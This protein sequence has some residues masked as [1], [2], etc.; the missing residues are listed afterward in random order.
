MFGTLVVTLPSSYLGGAL[1]IRHGRREVTVETKAADPSEL[2]YVAF[3][4]DCEHETLPVRQ[5]SRVCLVYNLVQQRSKGRRRIQKAPEYESQITEAATILDRFLNAADAP[6][7]IVWLLDH[8]YS[9]AGLSFSTLK[10]ADAAKA[11]VLLRAATKAQCAAHL[12]IVHIG[13]SGEAESDFGYSY[14][15][16]RRSYAS[17][18]DDYNDIDNEDMD[19]TAASVD[20]VWRYI[21]EWRDTDDR[22]AAFGRIPLADG[23]LLP[24]GALDA[25]PPDKQ[26][27]TEA[28]GN[29]GA[30]YERSY[31][32]AALVVWLQRSMA[33]VLL[34]AGAVAALP[35]LKKL[36]A[37]GA[38]ERPEA[39]R[40]AERMLA[41]WSDYPNHWNAYA[42]YGA[43]PEPSDRR[44]MIAAL[45][46]LS[47]PALLE[48]FL[49]EAI[50]LSYDGS[51]NSALVSSVRV[52]GEDSAPGV[53]SAL[54]SARMP[55]HPV[56]C[57]ELLLALARKPAYAFSEVAE[58]AVAGIDRIGTSGAESVTRSWQP[59]QRRP[60]TPEFLENLLRALQSFKTGTL[61]DAAAQ[62]IASR[63]EIFS[64]V[65][66]VVPAIERIG[67]RSR[68]VTTPFDQRVKQYENEI[69][70]MR[71]L[72]TLADKSGDGALSGRM[73]AAVKLAPDLNK[74]KALSR[75]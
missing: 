46:S 69:A 30:T 7:K 25:E 50:T 27:V 47:A 48:R 60:L 16:R 26:R 29:E 21:D 40:V 52:L 11:R 64:P 14:R 53:L 44:E 43:R 55:D 10:G 39:M 2:S 75:K 28:T 12:A 20:D 62:K 61:C 58:A 41:V 42:I 3:F 4:A 1:R 32:R 24:A 72:L 22:V 9:P 31:L 38:S 17:Y 71:A 45:V 74:G 13:E 66:L 56:E 34:Q 68:K 63:P 35:Y 23:E 15:S 5:G 54:V 65:T 57:A 6:A 67:T 51:E 19:F 73:E 70:A 36:A 33:D 18:E 8:Q 59:E 37:G 49:R